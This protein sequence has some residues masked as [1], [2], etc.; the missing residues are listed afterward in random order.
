MLKIKQLLM[1]LSLAIL[2]SVTANASGFYDLDCVRDTNECQVRVALKES[3]F[4]KYSIGREVYQVHDQKVDGPKYN[5]LTAHTCDVFPNGSKLITK[6]EF[7]ESNQWKVRALNA[8]LYQLIFDRKPFYVNEGKT[9]H[10]WVTDGDM[11]C[12]LLK[13]NFGFKNGKTNIHNIGNSYTGKMST[14]DFIKTPKG[15]I[16]LEATTN[17][18]YTN[19]ILK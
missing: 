9:I 12:K 13:S 18:I 14:T 19:L 4:N 6:L 7:S 8:L 11:D 17:D 16:H 5:A 2:S 15:M 3:E 1:G 10:A